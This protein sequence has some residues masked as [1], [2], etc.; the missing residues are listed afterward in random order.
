VKSQRLLPVA[1][2]MLVGALL[3]FDSL[4]DAAEADYSTARLIVVY[5][6]GNSGHRRSVQS[7]ARASGAEHAR[8]SATGAHILELPRGTTAQETRRVAEQ[9]RASADIASVE[10]DA[11]ASPMLAQSQTSAFAGPSYNQYNFPAAL[12]LADA[13]QL[14]AGAALTPVAIVDSGITVHTALPPGQILPGYN[15]YTYHNSSRSSDYYDSGDWISQ[16]EHDHDPAYANCTV[17]NSHWHGTAMAGLIGAARAANYPGEGVASGVPL[18]PARA[19]GKCGGYMSDVIEA[20][21]WAGG[22]SLPGI[23][24][25]PNPV[26][27]INMS[28]GAAATCSAYY[29]NAFDQLRA[30]GVVVVAAGGNHREDTNQVIPA[31]CNGVLAIAATDRNGELA[32]YSASGSNVTVAAPGGEITAGISTTSNTGLTN[33]VSETSAGYYGTSNSTAIVSGIVS[34]ML[35]ANPALQPSGVANI[36]KAT[37]VPMSGCASNCGGGRVDANAAVRMALQ[38]VTYTSPHW[39]GMDV[40]RSASS[41]LSVTNVSGLA[42]SFGQSTISGLNAGDFRKLADTC[43][44]ATLNDG[45]ACV[46][47]ISFTPSSDGTRQAAVQV[48]SNMPSGGISAE[49]SATGNIG[50]SGNSAAGAAVASNSSSA[51]GG[52]GGGCAM[53]STDSKPDPSLIA[54]TLMAALGLVTGRRQRK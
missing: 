51:G 17:A 3:T 28:L 23:P 38:G 22:I 27:I 46:I 52:G 29:Q 49:L 21:L 40:G 24:Y 39:P 16:A 34:L 4:A 41:L 6:D 42:V 36:L 14:L 31:A 10:P 43:S 18:L 20:A 7:I 32:S 26:R 33:P 44:G 2:G 13:R 1:I 54:L 50:T 30:A 5:K 9:L 47:S 25:N 19:L 37:A 11:I 12:D 53:S 8:T 45:D 48:S 15:F 35:T